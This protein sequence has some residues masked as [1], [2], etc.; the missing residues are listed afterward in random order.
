MLFPIFTFA[1]TKFIDEN[2][3]LTIGG[4]EQWITIGGND[5][6]KPVILFIHGGPGSVMSPYNDAIYGEWKSEFILVNWDQRGAG[7]TYGRNTPKEVEEDF[8]IE[9]PLTVNQMVKDGIELTEYLTKYLNKKKVILIG[10][11]WGS[12]LG[13][14]MAQSRPDL[15]YAYLGHA[16]FVNLT[17]NLKNAYRKVFELSKNSGDNVSSK[18][19]EL[20]GE[21]PY[22]SAKD[23]GQFLRIVKKYERE[24][25]VPAPDDWWKL[26]PEY[27]NEEDN[28]NRYD[29]D[30]YSF[31][32]FAGHEK[33]GI[34]SMVSDID[35]SK[36]GREYKIP[37]YLIQ[38]EEDIL[39]SS[40]INKLYFDKIIAPEKEYFL[41][42]NTGHGHN[43]SVVDAQY[44]ILTEKLHFEQTMDK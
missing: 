25:S 4:I 35:F 39:T 21:P 44:K 8:W 10:T 37:V 23:A 41:L 15:Y 31:I 20:L 33:L 36:E 40:E 32:Y 38:G 24:N 34:K 17:E 11:S 5:I 13:A 1:Q 26:A 29:G 3:Y 22:V 6:N 42:P 14:K 30:D 28:K 7:R 19:L 43:K 12:I 27:D 9:N 16:Q 18:K 2:K